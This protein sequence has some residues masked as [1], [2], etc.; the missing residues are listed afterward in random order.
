[1][2]KLMLALKALNKQDLTSQTKV[3]SLSHQIE[4]DPV[5]ADDQNLDLPISTWNCISLQI[6]QKLLP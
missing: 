6:L 4:K 5:Q 1:M 2:I 3:V